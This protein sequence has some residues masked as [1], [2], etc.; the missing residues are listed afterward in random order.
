ML[1]SAVDSPINQ[2]YYG[3][4]N[5]PTQLVAALS[6]KLIKNHAFTNGNK[7]TALLAA[8][9][10]L[11]QHGKILQPNLHQVEEN[12]PLRQAHSDV[13]TGKVN[14][15][16]LADVCRNLW[17]TATD[18][19]GTEAADLCKDGRTDFRTKLYAKAPQ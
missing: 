5:D 10:V 13:A 18:A 9:L 6:Y 19:N 4:E 14:E 12:E 11:T 17:Q 3:K 1:K 15:S 8:N 16:D 7:R 2:Q